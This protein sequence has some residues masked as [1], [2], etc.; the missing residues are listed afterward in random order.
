MGRNRSNKFG[1]AVRH[2][3]SNQIDEKLELLSEIP[4][5]NI[6]NL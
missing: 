2:L 6:G 3:K 4:T 1:S 5:N